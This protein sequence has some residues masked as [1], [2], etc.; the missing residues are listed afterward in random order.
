MDGLKEFSGQI[1][2]IFGVKSVF[3]RLQIDSK[4]QAAQ[5]QETSS[6][7]KSDTITKE[8]KDTGTDDTDTS[9][10]QRK[11]E[12]Q[13]KKTEKSIDLSSKKSF[14]KIEKLVIK[15]ISD[16][17]KKVARQA[18]VTFYEK[19][20]EIYKSLIEKSKETTNENIFNIKN[21]LQKTKLR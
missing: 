13:I 6:I 2:N 21:K 12:K 4:E 9:Q 20:K 3:K 1:Q 10:A 11:I 7:N 14:D 16:E 18:L 19:F 5:P 17:E 8:P 15:D